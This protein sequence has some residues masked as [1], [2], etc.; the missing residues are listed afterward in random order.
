MFSE[1]VRGIAH[2]DH[3]ERVLPYELDRAFSTACIE[4]PRTPS[5]GR[6]DDIAASPAVRAF[7]SQMPIGASRPMKRPPFPA[8]FNARFQGPSDA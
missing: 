8:I 3:C 7:R 6:S 2:H 1:R 5:V 4:A